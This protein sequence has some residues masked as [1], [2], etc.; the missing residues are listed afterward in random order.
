MSVQLSC[1][2]ISQVG[3][4]PPIHTCQ[5]TLS[6]MFRSTSHITPL[7]L[8]PP[9]P[10]QSP[11]LQVLHWATPSQPKY[12]PWF[13]HS[14]PHMT[15]LL[16]RPTWRMHG[17]PYWKSTFLRR[18]PPNKYTWELVFLSSPNASQTR[19]SIG[20]TLTLMN[21]SPSAIRDAKIRALPWA[22]PPTVQPP[23]EILLPTMGKLLYYYMAIMA[24]NGHNI[25]MCVL[26]LIC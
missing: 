23:G 18:I 22:R 8:P 14:G 13:P 3:P 17:P 16:L 9:P 7:P 4:R 5:S 12:H 25:M 15:P 24:S 1:Q 21:S 20:S 2:L 26:V 19:C 11:L 10:S 6:R